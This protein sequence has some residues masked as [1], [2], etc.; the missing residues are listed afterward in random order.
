MEDLANMDDKISSSAPQFATAEY[1]AQPGAT[2]CK[3]CGQ[4]ISG[5]HYRVNGVMTCVKCAQRI[6]DQMPKDS[7][8]AYVRGISFGIGGAILGFAIYAGFSLATGWMIGYISLAVGFIV[9]KAMIMGSGGL[10]GR[11]YQIAAVV[12]TYAAVSMAAVPIAIS[13]HMKHKSVQQQ[14]QMSDSAAPKMSPI[15]AIGTLAVVGLASPFLELSDPV[16]GVI[17]LIILFVGIRIAWKMT[18]GRPM[19]IVGPLLQ[20]P[21]PATAI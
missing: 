17:G 3:A 6:Q 8:A 13:Q 4:A 7:H 12:L 11:R 10:G 1:S 5:S 20:Q 18:A 9:G 2:P 15:K 14:T 19:N 21:S 16:H